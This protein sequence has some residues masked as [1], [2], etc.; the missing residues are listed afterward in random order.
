MS[1]SSG[2]KTEEPT[3]KKLADSRKK[4]Q[5]AQSQ[6][7]NKLFVTVAGFQLLLAMYDIYFAD[8]TR[9][10]TLT[11]QLVNYDFSYS[12]PLL[13]REAFSTWSRTI[14]PFLAAVILARF[15]ASFVQY[16]ILIAPESFKI[17]LGKLSPVKNGK[18]II[19][20]KKFL[21]FI[22]N[23][24][25]T[26]VLVTIVYQVVKSNLPEILMLSLTDIPVSLE[27]SI[28]V[29]R[30]ILNMVMLTF[31][32][33]SFA[34]F[35]L[36][37]KIFIKSMKMTKDEVFREYKQSEGDPQTKADR[38]AV[39]DQIL[40]SEGGE[41]KKTVADSDAVVVNPTHFAVALEYKPGKTPLPII[42]AKG[43][44]KNA[45]EIIEI[46]K[47]NNVPVIRYVSLARHMYRVGKVG[48]Y[49]PRDCLSQM[50][51]VFIAI[52]EINEEG[53]DSNITREI[54]DPY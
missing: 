1:E 38:K 14:L 17:D 30:S 42:R 41:I 49:I 22:G 32:V 53:D 45:H 36:Q 7:V 29:F 20:K 51:A 23:I 5:V 19:S 40:N 26:L 35:V 50:A 9:L 24:V 4:G 11:Y 31:L 12:G 3:S 25:K 54:K 13:A 43:M 47:E 21:E 37:K 46:A 16:G 33:I 28:H 2:E 8:I 10:I 15:V 39:G 27:F 48:K 44:D 34:D 52:R 18:N 6:D